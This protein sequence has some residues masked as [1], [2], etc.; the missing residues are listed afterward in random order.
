MSSIGQ[1]PAR[2][3]GA[4]TV[5]TALL[6]PWVQVLLVG[7]VL[8]LGLTWATLASRNFHLVPSV[9][10]LGAFLGPVAFVAYVYERAREVPLPML[11]WCF[12]VGGVVGVTAASVLEYRTLMDLGT[13]PTIAIGL[14][15]ESCKLVVPVAIFMV[16]RYRR[17]ADGLLFG[18]ASG[19]GFAA[20]ESMGY[21]LTAL[22]LSHGHIGAVEKLLFV[23]GALSPAGH[24]AWTGLICAMLWRSRVR[25]TPAAKALAVATFI[26]AATLHAIWDSASHNWVQAAV[27]LVSLSLLFWRID[28][29]GRERPE[30]RGVAPVPW[31]RANRGH[32][33]V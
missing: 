3:P 12:I 8:W 21:G 25:P 32:V 14:I 19:L 18:V 30:Q 17:E 5:G 27:A 7:G 20:F 16:G 28:A 24:G 15:E 13:L 22:F 9:I 33:E 6:R 1:L 31:T 11:L 23:R 4:S 2:H 29:S 10:V 26:A